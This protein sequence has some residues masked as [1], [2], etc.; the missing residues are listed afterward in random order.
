MVDPPNCFAI[1][2]NLSAES[3]KYLEYCNEIMG[4]GKMF[5]IVEPK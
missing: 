4:V 5:Y 3:H 2:M 1:I